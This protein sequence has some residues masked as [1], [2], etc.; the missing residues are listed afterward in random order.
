MKLKPYTVLML[1]PDYMTDGNVQ[2][3]HQH[4]NALTPEMAVKRVRIEIAD[5]HPEYWNYEY[6]SEA[7]HAQAREQFLMDLKMIGVWEGHNTMVL[8]EYDDV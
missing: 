4:T 8:C 1:Y 6:N 2:T 5:S 7:E 3:Y